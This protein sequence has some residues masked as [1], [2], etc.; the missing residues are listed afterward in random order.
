[1]TGPSST[2]LTLALTLIEACA[3]VAFALSGLIAAARK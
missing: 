2:T 1:M 3:T